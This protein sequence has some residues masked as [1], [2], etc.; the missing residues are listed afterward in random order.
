M[1]DLIPFSGPG[2]PGLATALADRQP[3]RA[4]LPRS[5]LHIKL[6][7][8]ND[9]PVDFCLIRDDHMLAPAEA[10]FGDRV[11]QLGREARIGG[12]TVNLAAVRRSNFRYYRNIGALIDKIRF[13]RLII[14]LATEPL[15]EFIVARLPRDVI[16]IWE[17]GLMHYVD[18]E[19]PLFRVRRRLVQKLCGF[20]VGRLSGSTI[21]RG[22]YPVRDRFREGSLR[23]HRPR[24]A[25]TPRNEILYIGQPLVSDGMI[26]LKAYAGG[27][28]DLARALPVPLR[29]LPHP[30]ENDRA[31]AALRAAVGNDALRVEADRRGVIEHCADWS[32]LAYLS[33]FSTALLDLGESGRSFWVAS[34][35]GLK[36]RGRRLGAFRDAPVAVPRA[37]EELS[38]TLARLAAPA[39][40]RD[41]LP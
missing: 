31:V 23:M 4:A 27:L 1:A 7:K 17:E 2:I 29:Y 30:R 37:L 3:I 33:P 15:E 13:E 41:P 10:A 18:M 38:A 36:D 35:V 8:D 21:D 39:I 5:T 40:P 20:H 11:V 32:Y 9:A 16:E 25:Q 14:F 28:A 12:G 34:L 24:R 6:L 22:A 26:D 19:G